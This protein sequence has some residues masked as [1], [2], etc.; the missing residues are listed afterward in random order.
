MRLYFEELNHLGEIPDAR[1]FVEK[2][3]PGLHNDFNLIFGHHSAPHVYSSVNQTLEP[4]SPGWH[5]FSNGLPND[6]WPKSRLLKN[7]AEETFQETELQAAKGHERLELHMRR[8]QTFPQETLPQTG[9]PEHFEKALSAAF[10]E[11]PQYGTISQIRFSMHQTATMPNPSLICHEISFDPH[12]PLVETRLQLK[13]TQ[14]SH[15]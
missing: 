3:T 13:M 14:F 7:F 10:I 4:L 12:L 1:R 9:V 5:A 15:S 11:T 6:L 2:L 8:K